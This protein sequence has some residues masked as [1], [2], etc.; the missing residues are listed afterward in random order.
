MRNYSTIQNPSYEEIYVSV[1]L[2]GKNIY[3]CDEQGLFLPT[4]KNCIFIISFPA[5]ATRMPGI[6]FYAQ[7]Y[8]N[9]QIK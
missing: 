9:M 7:L 2:L 8:F 1:Q 4:Y 5:P 6:K 3:F